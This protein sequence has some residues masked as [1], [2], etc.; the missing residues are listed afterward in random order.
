M[1]S[2]GAKGRIHVSEQTVAEL[3]MSGFGHWAKPRED[4]VEAKGKGTL[5][6]YW[7][8]GGNQSKSTTTTSQAGTSITTTT[9]S[10]S[11]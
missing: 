4:L 8:D 10:S 2:N 1:E 9:T 11:E 7:I 5:Q 3:Q 6:T